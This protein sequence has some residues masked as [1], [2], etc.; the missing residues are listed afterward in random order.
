M[1]IIL[2]H[3]FTIKPDGN[4]FTLIKEEHT[5][6]INPE[7]KKEIVSRGVWYPPT[8][9]DALKRYMKESLRTCDSLGAVL[10]R[11]DEVEAKID[12]LKIK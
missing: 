2:D 4:N 12:N 5:G 9:K 1:E 6:K 7:T 3:A 8:L 11:L 10:V